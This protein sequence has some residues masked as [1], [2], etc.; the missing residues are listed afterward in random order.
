MNDIPDFENALE[1]FRRFL[2]EQGHP[3]NVFWVFREDIWKRSP[4]SVVLRF[5]SQIKNL[6]LAKKVFEEGREKG[7]VEV[8]AIATVGDKVAATV[9][10]PRFKE[11][12]IQGWECGMKLSIVEPLPSAEIV[13]EL[14][15]LLFSLKPQFR[16]Y[17]RFELWVGTKAWATTQRSTWSRVADE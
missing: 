14:R 17:Q 9:W 12:E 13:G 16:H 15:W 2:A 3:T 11:E 5:P 6:G 10:F 8:R 4:T 7:L 1:S